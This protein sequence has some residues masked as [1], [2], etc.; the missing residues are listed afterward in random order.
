MKKASNSGKKRKRNVTKTEPVISEAQ[1]ESETVDR[2]IKVPQGSIRNEGTA[3][4]TARV[5]A[6]EEDRSK[7]RKMGTNENLKSLFSSKNGMAE[8]SVDFMTRGFSIPAGAKR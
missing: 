2:S 3:S 7:R 4:L 5:L 8:K 1:D 6:E